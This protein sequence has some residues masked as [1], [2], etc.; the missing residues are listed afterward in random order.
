MSECFERFTSKE[1]SHIENVTIE[2][3]KFLK[4]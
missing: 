2:K 4:H 1:T 3:V